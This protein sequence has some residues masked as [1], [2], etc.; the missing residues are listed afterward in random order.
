LVHPFGLSESIQ[1]S[2]SG[3]TILDW[4]VLICFKNLYYYYTSASWL[5]CRPTHLVILQNYINIFFVCFGKW[6]DGLH[7]RFIFHN[8]FELDITQFSMTEHDKRRYNSIMMCN[9]L[10]R[11]LATYVTDNLSESFHWKVIHYINHHCIF[12][13]YFD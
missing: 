3:Y 5:N 8:Y 2:M 11:K 7:T 10:T 13:H 12:I 4:I 1:K 6:L 9:T